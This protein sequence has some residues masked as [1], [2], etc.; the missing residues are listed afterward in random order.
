M[1]RT[2]RKLG[3]PVDDF[4]VWLTGRDL[5]SSKVKVLEAGLQSSTDEYS[6]RL[7]L[8]GFF[9]QRS[10]L[11][12]LNAESFL[13][14]LVWLIDNYP[15]KDIHQFLF[16]LSDC[17]QYH[18][19]K[20]HWCTQVEMHPKNVA[21]LSNAAHFCSQW[22]TKVS[23]ELW[24]HACALEPNNGEWPVKLCQL[25]ISKAKCADTTAAKGVFASQA[26]RMAIKAVRLE[27]KSLDLRRPLLSGKTLQD[28]ADLAIEPTLLDDYA[29]L[30]AEI[31]KNGIKSLENK[32]N[33]GA[34][35]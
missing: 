15:M 16:F 17:P 32:R 26:I 6:D 30:K 3:H 11:D 4:E 24:Q 5:T 23:E 25:H 14:H 12:K 1:E 21:V 31:S 33:S 7:R 2:K 13:T 10:H 34:D 19:A 29:Q 27:S 18:I 35:R 8:L 22:D 20:K 28:I 9:F